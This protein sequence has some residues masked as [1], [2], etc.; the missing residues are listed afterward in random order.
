MVIWFGP[1]LAFF[2]LDWEYDNTSD[3]TPININVASLDSSSIANGKG[4]WNTHQLRLAI[5]HIDWR[6]GDR[7]SIVGIF[8]QEGVFI[9]SQSHGRSMVGIQERT[10]A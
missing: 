6:S 8:G 1:K 9:G 2:Y 7:G 10:Q 4:E 3:N 5:G